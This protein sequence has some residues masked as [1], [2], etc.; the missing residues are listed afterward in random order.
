MF[1]IFRTKAGGYQCF[2]GTYLTYLSVV[3]VLNTS[4]AAEQYQD[5]ITGQ[6]GVRLTYVYP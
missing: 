1:Y 6:H 3:L 5:Q 4:T 2:T